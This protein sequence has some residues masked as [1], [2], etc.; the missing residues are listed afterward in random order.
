MRR[1]LRKSRI[2]IV[3]RSISDFWIAGINYKKTD[4]TI[5]GQY[6]ISNDQYTNILDK[7]Y[8]LGYRE[9]FIVSTCNR[10]EIYAVSNNFSPL[11]DI[12][13]SETAGSKEAFEELAYVKNGVEAIEHLFNV[14]AGLDSQ[15]L[16][17]YEILGQVK[18]A[19]KFAKGRGLIGPYMER[20]IN[21]AIQSSKAIKSNTE[22][23]GGTVSVS[24]AAVQYIREHIADYKHKK[25][26]LLGTGK[27]G[28]NTCKNLVDYLH[29][30]NITLVNRTAEKAAAL[31][32]EMGLKYAPVENMEACIREADII[33]TSTNAQQPI[34]TRELLQNC[35][36]KLII[37][38][39]I[40]YNV[41]RSVNE[42]PGI[43]LLNVDELSRLK[44]ENLQKRMAEVPKAKRII[45]EHICEFAQWLEKRKHAKVL[46]T[47]KQ[48]LEGIDRCPFFKAIRDTF[49]V[50]E[51]SI[52]KVVNTTAV[53]LQAQ[54]NR[55]CYYIEA[56]NEFIATK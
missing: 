35:G 48:T 12:L 47:L 34:I 16:G 21:S 6:A 11:I 8:A 52:Q 24:F 5:R 23:S 25:I 37:D 51:Q 27:I 4:A 36:N 56:I 39:A 9:L 38:L 3:E 7:S 10:T 33:I 31:A 26:L 44:D 20:W 30:R 54:D 13:C 1:I 55:G 46:R 15:V 49:T 45:G 32:S 19:A 18:Q 28:K 22:L 14:S 50:D 40:P 2:T 43:D 29:N 42:L 53:K 17:D 41:E